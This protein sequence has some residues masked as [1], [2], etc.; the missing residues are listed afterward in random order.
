MRSLRREVFMTKHGR[1]RAVLRQGQIPPPPPPRARNHPCNESTPHFARADRHASLFPLPLKPR[2]TPRATAT[3]RLPHALTVTRRV[4]S[5]PSR[6][7][8]GEM[9]HRREPLDPNHTLRVATTSSPLFALTARRRGFRPGSVRAKR[10]RGA[11]VTT[12]RPQFQR[13]WS[14]TKRVGLVP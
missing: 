6:R 14:H 4:F 11:D 9:Q 3:R 12:D 2:R 13:S 1:G 7:P 8:E 5:S 10:I